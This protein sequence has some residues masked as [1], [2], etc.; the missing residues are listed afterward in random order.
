[1]TI[2]ATD[3]F[4]RADAGSLG[5]NW[6][7]KNNAPGIV[8][9]A[10]DVTVVDDNIAYYSAISWPADHYAQVTVKNVAGV[11]AAAVRL[12][13]GANKDGYYGG[14]DVGNV[15]DASRTLF[16]YVSGV[17]TSLASE[18]TLVAVNDVLKTT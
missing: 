1:M 8:S 3:G 16:K 12:Q 4:N 17:F 2:L 15:G 6:T 5:G 18:A 11:A 10:V 14:C 7:N 13:T 9:N